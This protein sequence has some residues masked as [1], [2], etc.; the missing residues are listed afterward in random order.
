MN[1]ESQAPSGQGA[2]SETERETLES[3]VDHI[4]QWCNAVAKDSFIDGWEK[5][6]RYFAHEGGLSNARAVLA[7]PLPAPSAPA[8]TEIASDAYRRGQ[9]DMQR[10]AQ[11]CV[12]SYGRS[13]Y[14]RRIANLSYAP[15]ISPLK[16]RTSPESR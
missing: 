16:F 2:T 14:A 6:Y 10:M 13:D 8:E 5:H 15:Y 11:N 1:N 3:V 7:K 9:V 12:L 4:Q